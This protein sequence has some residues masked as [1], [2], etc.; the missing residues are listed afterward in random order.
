[1][2]RWVPILLGAV[3]A[4]GIPPLFISEP[5]YARIISVAAV[6][7]ILW[8]TEVTPPFVPT[9]LLWALV[10]LTLTPLDPRFDLA[11][12]LGWAA[13]PVLALFFGGFSLGV[14]AERFGVDRL[15]I[16]SAFRASGDSFFRLLLLVIFITAF[17]SMW[18]SNIAAAALMLAC[19]RP[20]FDGLDGDNILRRCLLI[21]VALGADL[22][23]MATPIGTGPN[24]VA[25]A[26][27]SRD[28]HVSFLDWM[29]FAFPL[30]IGMLLFSF[31]LLWIRVRRKLPG[32]DSRPN[33]DSIRPPDDISVEQASGRRVFLAIMVATIALWLSEPLHNVSASIVSIGAVCALFLTRTLERDSIKRIDWSTLILI[34]GGITLGK[35][36][37]DSGI[38]AAGSAAIPFDS[39]SP[40]VALFIICLFTAFL[41][42]IMSN[43]ASVIM[44]I[45]I[46]LAL[47]PSPSTAVLVAV[48]A[49]FGIPFI[50]STPPNAMA[51]GEGGLRTGDIFWPGI[52]IMILGCLIVSTTGPTILRF[53]G[54]P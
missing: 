41:A 5:I 54:I 13:D 14:A 6:C 39:Y 48:S 42:A 38:I 7:L 50:I 30:T 3:A 35:L 2:R 36:F 18:L 25:I 46:A 32:Q 15:M 16:R 51:Y 33:F 23:G 31:G 24:A 20:A 22:G 34:S 4:V 28:L 53:A 47:V 37:E 1:M 45:P 29:T 11:R 44:L 8:L 27:L 21:G 52:I 9:L 12:V 43:T 10:P 17:L 19:L 40:T 49:S 26:A